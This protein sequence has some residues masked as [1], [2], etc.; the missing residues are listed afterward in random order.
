MEVEAVVCVRG[1]SFSNRGHCLLPQALDGQA[2]AESL[3]AHREKQASLGLCKT[4]SLCSKSW[5]R[6]GDKMYADIF[7]DMWNKNQNEQHCLAPTWSHCILS[8]LH[9]IP[10]ISY[11]SPLHLVLSSCPSHR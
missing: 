2:T 7:H 10:V 5:R 1:S 9:F 3:G 11:R 6:R 4:S 8:P